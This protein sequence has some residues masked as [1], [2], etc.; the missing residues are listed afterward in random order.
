MF[1]SQKGYT[2]GPGYTFGAG[3]TIKNKRRNTNLK[4]EFLKVPFWTP[5]KEHF[6][7]LKKTPQKIFSL[8]FRFDSAL[9]AIDTQMF[10]WSLFLKTHTK[11]LLTIKNAMLAVNNGFLCVF[12]N[13]DQNK[14]CASIIFKAKT[15]ENYEEKLFLQF[16]NRN[17]KMPF[18]GG[19]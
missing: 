7:F 17:S 15:K 5:E 10:F 19:Q 6:W 14:I 13:T 3:Y 8:W 12:K 18:Y 1:Q 16:L 9:K 11:K 2:F 4:F